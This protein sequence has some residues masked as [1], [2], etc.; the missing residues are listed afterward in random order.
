[1]TET[2]VSEE[3][4]MALADGELDADTA[5]LVQ[6]ELG[7]NPELK[8]F[9]EDMSKSRLSLINAFGDLGADDKYHELV[10]V[11]HST[12]SSNV[13]QVNF[14]KRNF[15]ELSRLAA[16]L[17]IGTVLG[18]VSWQTLG[19]GTVGTPPHL[20]SVAQAPSSTKFRPLSNKNG[21][22]NETYDL[23]SLKRLII[24]RRSYQKVSSMLFDATRNSLYLPKIEELAIQRNST[25]KLAVQPKKLAAEPNSRIEERIS[26]ALPEAHALFVGAIELLRIGGEKSETKA[27]AL[28]QEASQKGHPLASLAIGA[29]AV[30]HQASKYFLRS[31]MQFADI[32]E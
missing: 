8:Q 18:G 28:L 29:L 25:K 14:F 16:T 15:P 7:K 3:M 21:Q 9:Y 20:D 22:T 4:V 10:Q 11:I 19:P 24:V 17:V 5:K 30:P 31:A 27:L 6:L 1:M 2:T 13:V 23:Q 12:E 32:A 26:V